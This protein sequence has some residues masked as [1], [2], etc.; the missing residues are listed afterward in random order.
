MLERPERGLG[1]AA[2]GKN[3]FDG[4]SVRRILQR[5]VAE[6]HCL[7]NELAD[8]YSL[9]EL[10]EMAAEAGISREAL[11]IAIES[12][13]RYP[14]AATIGL[15]ERPRGWLAFLQRQM[16]ENWSPAAKGI[17]LMSAAGI[18][19]FGVLLAFPVVAQVL[20]WATIVLLVLILLGASP[21]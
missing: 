5:A 6:Q 4:E 14:H 9:E 21:F 11:R 7:D 16:P 19:L 1:G 17:V 12:P 15:G 18:A 13:A 3:R 20:F 8:T 10:E 2:D